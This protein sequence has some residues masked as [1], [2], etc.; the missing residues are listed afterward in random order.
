[1]NT[2]KHLGLS[3]QL[4]N[5]IEK[6]HFTEPTQIQKEAIPLILQ[7]K[8]VIGE[9]ATGSGKTLAFGAGIIE[10]CEPKKGVQAIVL[11]PTRELAEQVKDEMIKLSQAKPLHIIAVYGGVSIN[12]QMHELKRA[13]VVISTPGR[14]LDHLSRGSIDNSKVKIL[15]LDEADKMV[16]MGFITDVEKILQTCPKNRQNLLFSA[17]MYGPAKEIA[18]RYMNNPAFVRATQMVDPSKLKQYYYD[19]PSKSKKEILVH[20]LKQ[21]SSD[22]VMI[23][24]NTRIAT[25]VVVDVLKANGIKASAIHGGLNQSKRLQTIELFHKGKFQVLVCTDVAARGLHIEGVTHIYNYDIPKDS[26][27]Y[28]HRIGRTARAGRTGLVINILSYRDYDNFSRLLRDHKEF[29]IVKLDKPDIT[30]PFIV[31][32]EPLRRSDS[33]RSDARGGSQGSRGGNRN[34]GRGDGRGPRSDSRG[35]SQ[36]SRGGSQGSRG[37]SQG[38]RGGSQGSRG[39]SQGSRGGSQGSRG[40]SRD[41]SREDS[42]RNTR[43]SSRSNRSP[44]SDRFSSSSKGGSKQRSPRSE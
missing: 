9:S 41:D 4:L 30:T 29:D 25:D 43:S 21:D 28:V 12:P 32:K 3:T 34:A 20:L 40:G 35:G 5:A 8:D 42:G 18:K 38:S 1:M 7:G 36:G 44:P 23:F 33:Y 19:V 26:G 13:D 37:G 14:M 24:C 16:E 27:D 2:F 15:V 10:V 22:L 6:L 31:S 17:T 39:G 11:L